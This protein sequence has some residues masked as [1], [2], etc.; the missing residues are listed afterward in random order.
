MIEDS[1]KDY[2]DNNKDIS[3]DK[4]NSTHQVEKYLN[5]VNSSFIK[6]LWR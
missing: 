5:F 4:K 1:S 6:N 3:S 2:N